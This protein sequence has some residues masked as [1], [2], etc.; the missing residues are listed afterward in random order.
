MRI[1]EFPPSRI[2][3]D[4]SFRIKLEPLRNEREDEIPK[5]CSF[6]PHSRHLSLFLAFARLRYLLIPSSLH[7]PPN[8]LTIQHQPQHHPSPT[9]PNH[10]PPEPFTI[11]PRPRLFQHH[12]PPRLPSRP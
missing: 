2:Y 8:P 3:H 10:P 7:L 11:R 5:T 9:Q 12:Q 6:P 1:F 4:I